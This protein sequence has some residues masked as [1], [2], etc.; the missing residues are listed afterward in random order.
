VSQNIGRLQSYDAA[1][2]HKASYGCGEDQQQTN[3]RQDTGIGGANAEHKA[4]RDASDPER[5]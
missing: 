2:W 5:E 4:A 3:S 1:G